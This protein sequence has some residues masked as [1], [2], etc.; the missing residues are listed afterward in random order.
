MGNDL[1]TLTTAC[2]LTPT[3]RG[4]VAVVAV[5][6]PLAMEIV[7]RF[8]QPKSA[9]AL[10]D[11]PLGQIV[12]GRWG[13]QAAEDVIVCRRDLRGLE[14]HCHGGAAAVRRI[15][16][17]LIAAGAEEQDWREH[18]GQ[19]ESSAIRAAARIALVEAL[20]T[21][22][23]E[24]LLDQYHGALETALCKILA[25]INDGPDGLSAAQSLTKTLLDRAPLGLHLTKP[26]RVVV[27]GPPNVGKSSLVNALVGYQRAIV[28]DQPGTTRDVVTALTALA[29]W[30]IELCDTAGWR[31][32]ADPLEA[33]GVARAQEQA[34]AAD[35][36]L[37]VFDATQ[38]WSGELRAL[39]DAWP[40]ALLVQNKC[41]LLTPDRPGSIF[42][43]SIQVSA[44][45]GQGLDLLVEKIIRQVVPQEPKFGEPLPFTSEQIQRLQAVADA[46]ETGNLSTAKAHVL[47]LLSPE[48]T[49]N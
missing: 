41:D 14:V 2:M 45:T 20:T 47:A 30:P 16:D 4:A 40:R 32:T 49:P 17:D 13:S 19:H 10:A 31:S 24:I 21:R 26:W 1:G 48:E 37:L 5:E 6:G 29:G 11:R 23:A 12:Y 43:N 27:A 9:R 33:A 36:L 42:P 46:L 15:L 28:F 39:M 7:Q 38:S 8:F 3:G 22:T 44:V 34:S 25:A 35:A 18:I